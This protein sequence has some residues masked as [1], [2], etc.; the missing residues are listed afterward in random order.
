VAKEDNGVKKRR[1]CGE[2]VLEDQ[3]KYHHQGQLASC[4]REEENPDK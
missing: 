2:C 4:S 1:E 3:R